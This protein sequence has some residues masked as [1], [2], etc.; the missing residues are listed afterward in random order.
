M[1]LIWLETKTHNQNHTH[2]EVSD[3]A[4]MLKNVAPA[5]L[6]MHL[7]VQQ[8]IFKF[9]LLSNVTNQSESFQFQGGQTKEFL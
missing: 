7:P 6:A 4:L 2:L 1:Y 9:M 8:N 5:W 3:D